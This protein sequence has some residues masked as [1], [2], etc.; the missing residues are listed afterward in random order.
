MDLLGNM[1]IQLK[2]YYNLG[3]SI[4]ANSV[5]VNDFDASGSHNLE[6]NR[7]KGLVTS[8]FFLEIFYACVKLV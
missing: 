8:A 4:T 6:K 5:T 1:N 7:S 2:K 3:V